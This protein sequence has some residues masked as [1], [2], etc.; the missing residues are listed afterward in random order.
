MK[1]NIL[2]L[3]Q[4][5]TV[6]FF[7]AFGLYSLFFLLLSIFIKNVV[8][9][10]IDNEAIKFISFVGVVYFIVWIIGLFVFYAESN[11]EEQNIMLNR[12]FGKYWFGIWT[13]PILWFLVTQLLRVK[14]I[15]KNIFLRILFS[16]MLIISIERFILLTISFHRDYLP[17]SW[18]IYNDLDIYPSNFILAVFC[19]IIVFFF[20]A[21]I[22]Y[23]ITS[24]FKMFQ[25]KK[26]E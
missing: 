6:D 15:Y 2:L 23:A 11:T 24:Q 1:E 21:G 14:R 8:L 22:Y 4:I 9:Y 20:F 19:K 13:Q 17:S 16:F 26:A 10:K 18:T 7:T 3:L 25:K 12:M 5:I